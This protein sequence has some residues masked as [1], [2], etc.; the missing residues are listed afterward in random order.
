MIGYL[1]GKL[2]AVEDDG[3][4][5][6]LPMGS[7]VGYSVTVPGAPEYAAFQAGAEVELQVYT[8]VREDAL[9]LFGFRSREEKDLFLALTSVNGI[10]P[11]LASGILA[12]ITAEDLIDAILNEDKGALVRVPGIG[13]KTAER[14]VL[15]LSEK[16]RKKV[17]RGELKGS[18]RQRVGSPA[19]TKSA[20]GSLALGRAMSLLNDAKSALVSLGYRES[21]SESVLRGVIKEHGADASG[22]R[23]EDLIRESLKQLR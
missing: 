13:K 6:V 11:K 5:I 2:L 10:G 21:E 23:V 18:S 9:D 19:G 20:Q 7:G 15:E 16:I 22:L 3:T 14:V 1:K 8:H 12:G 4:W 17:E